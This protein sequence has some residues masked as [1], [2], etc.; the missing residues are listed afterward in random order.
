MLLFPR[1]TKYKKHQK[2]KF[3]FCKNEVNYILPKNGFYG[4]KVLN[5]GRILNNQLEAARKVIRKRIKR[6]FCQTLKINLFTD[7]SSTKKSSGVRMGKGKGNLNFWYS[8]ASKGKI[9]F[10]VSKDVPKGVAKKAFSVAFFKFSVRCK[11]IE[12]FKNL[13]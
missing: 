8:C 4:L 6:K 1:K 5:T 7:L 13:D 3:R 11:F 2:G 12:T 9:I 10:E